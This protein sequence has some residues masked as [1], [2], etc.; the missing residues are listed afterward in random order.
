MSLDGVSL[1]TR[2]L[3]GGHE[4]LARTAFCCR[5]TAREEWRETCFC[6]GAADVQPFWIV[7]DRRWRRVM[8]VDIRSY[9]LNAAISAIVITFPA[10]MVIAQDAHFHN[11]P[12]SSNQLK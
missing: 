10:S 7:M 1:S 2:L 8:K 9:F 4:G 12:A 3:S 5:N 11:A 6:S